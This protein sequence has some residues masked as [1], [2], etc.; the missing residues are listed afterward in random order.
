MRQNKEEAK[1]RKLETAKRNGD[2][3]ENRIKLK[4]RMKK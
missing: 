1:N 2:D 4:P 3:N